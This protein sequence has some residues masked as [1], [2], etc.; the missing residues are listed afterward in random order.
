MLDFDRNENFIEEGRIEESIQSP[1][2][3][4]ITTGAGLVRR[5]SCWRWGHLTCAQ[6]LLDRGIKSFCSVPLLSRNGALGAL[7]VDGGRTPGSIRRM[8]NCQA[9]AQQIAIAVENALAFREIAALKDTLAKEKG[10]SRRGN[11]NGLQL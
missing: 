10:L 9:V 3:L 8:C 7:N 2:C 5:A 11:S 6:D 4:A 1:S